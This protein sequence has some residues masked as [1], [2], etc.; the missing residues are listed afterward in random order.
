LPKTRIPQES[1]VIEAL[2]GDLKDRLPA[3]KIGRGHYDEVHT[4]DLRDRSWYL[5]PEFN[6]S[7]LNDADL[8]VS[9]SNSDEKLLYALRVVLLE[10]LSLDRPIPSSHP[11]S[12]SSREVFRGSQCKSSSTGDIGKRSLAWIFFAE[13]F[14]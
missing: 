13:V 8:R 11:S 2:D 9:R 6:P 1:T 10:P 4:Q 5:S 3:S 14:I 12:A 7:G